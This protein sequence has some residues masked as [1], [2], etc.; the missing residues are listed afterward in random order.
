[1]NNGPVVLFSR[2]DGTWK[3]TD[4]GFTTE[5]TS[6]EPRP[7]TG[8]GTP[9]YRAPELLKEDCDATNKVDI[10][11][12]GCILFEVANEKKAFGSDIA[13]HEYTV[14]LPGQRISL[15]RPVE[16]YE[17]HLSNILNAMLDVDRSRRPSA[18]MLHKE[19]ATNL[20][21]CVGDRLKKDHHFDESAKA[22]EKGI[23][24]DATC[25]LLWRGLAEIY[26]AQQ[27]RSYRELELCTK[28]IKQMHEIQ[29]IHI[30]LH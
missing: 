19:F 1:M 30:R 5:G 25:A 16:T 20:W 14:S 24:A 13:V 3:I 10:W 18:T 6:N 8:S 22:Y 17:S 26:Q 27:L 12:L 29:G 23:E 11:G 15:L 7:T 9:G 4:F 28:K 21:K 2:K